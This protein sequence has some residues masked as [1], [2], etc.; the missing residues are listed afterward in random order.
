MAL[1]DQP[2]TLSVEQI[3]E[4]QTKLAT[5]RHDINN[6][7][8]LISA[9]IELS[10]SRPQMAEKM[11]ATLIDQPQKVSDAI[12]RFTVQFDQAMGVKR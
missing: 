4:L 12:S 3:K 7:L 10:R 11:M 2:V 5:L 9:T 1:P 6:T 8:S